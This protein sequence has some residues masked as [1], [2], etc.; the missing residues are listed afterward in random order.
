MNHILHD[1]NNE[2]IKPTC[3]SNLLSRKILLNT[4]VTCFPSTVLA[5]IHVWQSSKHYSMVPVIRSIDHQYYLDGWLTPAG[6]VERVVKGSTSMITRVKALKQVVIGN[7]LVLVWQKRPLY[8]EA[9]LS[10][11]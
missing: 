8:G 10:V 6:W 3:T 11:G 7:V 5:S 2:I 1:P 9:Y 4:H